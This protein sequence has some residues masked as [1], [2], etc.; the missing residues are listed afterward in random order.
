[1]RLNVNE[2]GRV[3]AVV[4]V[5]NGVDIVIIEE[6]YEKGSLHRDA[7]RLKQ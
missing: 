5:G 1:M 3:N 2:R 7:V 6:A 4:R